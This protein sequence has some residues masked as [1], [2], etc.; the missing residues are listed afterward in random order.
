MEDDDNFPPLA[1]FYFHTVGDKTAYSSTLNDLFVCYTLTRGLRLES[2]NPRR[3][4]LPL[5]LILY[6][7]RFAGFMNANPDP[8]LTLDLNVAHEVS[9]SS[10]MKLYISRK[11]SRT[12][13]ISMARIHLIPAQIERPED[14]RSLPYCVSMASTLTQNANETETERLFSTRKFAFGPVARF[15]LITS[16]AGPSMIVP[17]LTDTWRTRRYRVPRFANANEVVVPNHFT[18]D[19]MQNYFTQDITPTVYIANGLPA[20]ILFWRWWEPKF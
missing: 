2:I 17:F 15:R 5:E 18:P 19:F 9:G 7:T 14:V 12:H 20:R 13:L 3:P 6:I 4:A 16:A 11:L 8:S 10:N 1:E